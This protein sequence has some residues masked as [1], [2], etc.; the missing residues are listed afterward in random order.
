VS[1]PFPKIYGK[2]FVR[3]SRETARGFMSVKLGILRQNGG[4]A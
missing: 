1:T 3:D 4:L 2:I